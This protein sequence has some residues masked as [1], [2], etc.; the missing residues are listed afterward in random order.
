M[1]LIAVHGDDPVVPARV[2]PGK[3]VDQ[4][5]A[6]TPVFGVAD[7]VNIGPGREVL[8]GPVG[9][10]VIDEQNVVMKS[11]NFA[12]DVLDVLAFVED[13]NRNQQSHA[14]ASSF[15]ANADKERTPARPIRS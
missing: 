7:Q 5:L 11:A 8:A 3:G 6:V 2:G 10:A 15:A 12:Q 9:A 14:Q 4:A 1:L 13:R